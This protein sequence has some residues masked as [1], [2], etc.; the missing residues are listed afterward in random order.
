MSF[1]A[2]KARLIK[3]LEE[4]QAEIKAAYGMKPS[5]EPAT[6]GQDRKGRGPGKLTAVRDR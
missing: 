1:E 3:E 6:S 5:S 4:A 2:E